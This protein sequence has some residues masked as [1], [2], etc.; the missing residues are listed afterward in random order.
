[1]PSLAKSEGEEDKKQKDI[2]KKAIIPPK[3]KVKKE[4][5]EIVKPNFIKIPLTDQKLLSS[6]IT[7]D[8]V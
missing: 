3:P 6:A 1:M 8:S 2:K 7:S 4:E 5:K